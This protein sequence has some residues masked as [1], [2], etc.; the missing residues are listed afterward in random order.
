MTDFK[1]K[2][3]DYNSGLGLWIGRL[4]S[5]SGASLGTNAALR[6]CPSAT[7]RGHDTGNGLDFVGTADAHWGPLSSYFGTDVGSY[8]AYALNAW[9]YSDH[10]SVGAGDSYFGPADAI[11]SPSAVPVMGDAIWMDAWCSPTDVIPTDRYHG[12]GSA[13]GDFSIYRHNKSVNLAIL[14][15]SGRSVAVDNLK[16]LRWSISPGWQAP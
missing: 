2:S 16:T 13:I 15:G 9:F 5:Y 12:G 1:G 6:L 11:T 7:K 4:M 3:V 10:P 8:G 14:D